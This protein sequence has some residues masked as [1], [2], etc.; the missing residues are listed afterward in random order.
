MT[1]C[2]QRILTPVEFQQMH[3]LELQLLRELDRVC[4]KY[5]IKYVLWGGSMLGAI[6]HHGFIPWDDDADIAMTREEYEK[7]KNV[8]SELNP[9]ICF[10]QDNTTDPYYRWGYGKLR[11]TGTRYVRLG[12]EHLKSKDGVFIDIFPYDDIPLSLPFQKLQDFYCFCLRKIT[13]AEVGKKHGNMLSRM[14]Y[15]VLAQIPLSFVYRMLKSI[16]SKSNNTTPN[17][18][19]CLMYTAIGKLYYKHPVRERYGIP[20]K[21]LLERKEFEFEGMKL[22]GSKYFHEYLTYVFNNYMEIPPVSKR[23]QHAPVSLIKLI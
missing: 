21:W 6:R 2:K 17:K 7:F 13:W 16:H 14:W 20:K 18:A 15:T 10:F 1:A 22:Y 3:I 11:R 23:D 4:R 19:T 9:D 5:D 8:K 12:Q